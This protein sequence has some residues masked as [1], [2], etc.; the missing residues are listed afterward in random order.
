MHDHEKCSKLFAQLSEYIDRELD[1]VT[2]QSI[3]KHIAQCPP[4]QACLSTLKRTVAL[5]KQMDSDKVPQ[6][7]KQRLQEMMK[8]NF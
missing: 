8:Q 3:E 6:A 2:C 5:C 7:L 1:E 4:C